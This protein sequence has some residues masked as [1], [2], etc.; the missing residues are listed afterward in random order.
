MEIQEIQ[1]IDEPETKEPEIS[2]DWIFTWFIN[3]IWGFKVNR[4]LLRFLW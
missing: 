3:E 1:D 4:I 2:L